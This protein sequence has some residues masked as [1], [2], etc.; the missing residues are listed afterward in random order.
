MDEHGNISVT[1]LMKFVNDKMKNI[2]NQ[3]TKF[4]GADI[5][6]LHDILIARASQL[7]QHDDTLAKVRKFTSSGRMS[8]LILAANNLRRIIEDSPSY[9]PATQ[10]KDQLDEQLLNCKMRTINWLLP[11]K[12]DL[13]VCGCMYAKKTTRL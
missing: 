12:M 9:H 7:A 1:S 5:A 4:Y 6:N 13:R 2:P 8:D 3:T 11:R 10:L